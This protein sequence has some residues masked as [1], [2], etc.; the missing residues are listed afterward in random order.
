[1]MRVI[2]T[3]G[4]LSGQVYK[5]YRRR[6]LVHVKQMVRLGTGPA[7]TA[8][9]QRLGFSGRENTAFIERVN[10]TIR[11]GV[12]A[13]ARR[14]WAT[15]LQAPHLQ[16]HL[17]WRPAYYHSVRPHASFRVALGQ[18]PESGGKLRVQRYRQRTEADGS[19]ASQA[20]MDSRGGTAPRKDRSPTLD[21]SHAHSTPFMRS[22]EPQA[23]GW[24]L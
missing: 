1:M 18:S 3:A 17:H 19:R 7:F 8:A 10:L 2:H 11:R 15:A 16:A 12:A 9:L 13:L 23:H 14:T 21:T 20:Q 5:R 24:L 4:L 6:K 22:G